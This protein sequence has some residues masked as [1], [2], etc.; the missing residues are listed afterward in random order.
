MKAPEMKRLLTVIKHCLLWICLAHISA[1]NST[2][3]SPPPPVEMTTDNTT[4]FH[5]DP[6]GTPLM[7][8]NEAGAVVWKETYLPYGEKHQPSIAGGSN[9]IGYAGKPYDNA[10]GLSYMGARYYN[11]TLGRFT[12]IDPVGFNPD[13]L[14][15]HNRYA[16][17]N[18]NPYKYVDPDGRSPVA[19]AFIGA[20]GISLAVQDAYNG[21]QSGGWRGAA[22]SIATT[23]AFTIAFGLAGRATVNSINAVKSAFTVNKTVAKEATVVE[24]LNAAR[25]ARD[26]LANDLAPAKGKAPATVTGG[27]NTKTGEIAAKACGEGKCAED[28]VAKALGGSLDDI[29][30]TEAI[31]P[32]TGG[33]VPVCARCE[34]TYGRDAFPEGTRFKSD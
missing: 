11:P 24:N 8:T 6:A 5:L 32:R 31:R 21:Y 29:R 23:G 16:Y 34:A 27:Y 30:F 2:K 10:T 13:N 4:Y 3:P 12:G 26:A 19:V 28:H 25:T 15:S 7:A 33:E 1:A 9:T 22:N 17:A 14:H 18:N 20:V